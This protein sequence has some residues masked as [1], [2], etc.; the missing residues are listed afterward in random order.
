M[1]GAGVLLWAVMSKLIPAE[2]DAATH[3]LRLT[4]PVEGLQDHAQ[5]RITIE[6]ESAA[7]GGERTWQELNGI[8]AGERGDEFARV[9]EEMFPPWNE[10]E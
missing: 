1:N 7:T 6:E 5:M 4:E 8:M 2:Y 3:T 9:I 10:D